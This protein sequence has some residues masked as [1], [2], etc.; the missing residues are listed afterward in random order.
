MHT[1]AYYHHTI[2]YILCM[3]LGWFDQCGAGELA[4]KVADLTGKIEDG[5]GRKV[6]DFLQYFSQFA[7]GFIVAFYFSWKL[8]L[9]LLCS[10]PLIACAGAFMINAITAAQVRIMTLYL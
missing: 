7:V 9:V 1:Y 2:Y 5:I 10:L 4:T 3:L 8:T 6:G